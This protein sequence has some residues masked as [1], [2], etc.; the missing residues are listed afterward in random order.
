MVIASIIMKIALR[1]F[2][3][4]V[5]LCEVTSRDLD[6]G[7]YITL[8]VDNDIQCQCNGI[9]NCFDC[10]YANGTAYPGESLCCSLYHDCYVTAGNNSNS[11]AHGD[12]PAGC[13]LRAEVNQ[14]TFRDP[15]QQML[16]AILSTV[17]GALSMLGSSFIA[18]CILVRGYRNRG[19]TTTRDRLLLSMSVIDVLN[20]IALGLGPLPTPAGAIDNVA[21]AVGTEAS[22]EAQGFAVQLGL[23]S[24]PLY[25]SMLC[26][27]F[28]LVIGYQWDVG[29]IYKRIEWVFHLIPLGYGLVTASIG[30]AMDLFNSTST[31]CWIEPSPFAC[32]FAPGLEC[33]K[34]FNYEAYAWI[35]G[36]L[37]LLLSFACIF[38]T[39]VW[40]SRVAYLENRVFKQRYG[41]SSVSVGG[42]R[43]VAAV[44]AQAS[45][46]VLAFLSSYG[47]LFISAALK[48]YG[49]T[50]G[51]W[52]HCL[53][54]FFWPLQGF[55]NF[56]VFLRPT[57]MR[58]R[59]TRPTLRYCS[60]LY[61]AMRRESVDYVVPS[62]SPARLSVASRRASTKNSDGGGSRFWGPS[63]QLFRKSGSGENLDAVE[64][65]VVTRPEAA[66]GK[67]RTTGL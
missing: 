3:V 51:F 65:Q 53:Y 64:E 19:S 52:V 63:S 31:L 58:V 26:V 6:H 29:T 35:F 67:I 59:R 62:S 66:P 8:D 42:D 28:L 23:S 17:S 39:M 37:P 46:Y 50:H 47:F 30:V 41:E 24:I 33:T 20:S 13:Q 49:V 32:H 9:G 21:G 14:P 54:R 2:L 48:V 44:W 7:D 38:V 5:W 57:Y 1:L 18:F 22:C 12:W 56:F 10:F 45:L 36:G 55:W 61:V 16:L 34:G 27:F 11:F 60:A 25:N 43:Q 4:V 40:M 15:Q